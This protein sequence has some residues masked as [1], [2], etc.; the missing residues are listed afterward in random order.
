M[1]TFY[2]ICIIC[3][4][5]G[6]GALI[7]YASDK[8]TQK[9]KEKMKQLAQAIGFSLLGTGHN[10][11]LPEQF[12]KYLDR[13]SY[14]MKR[15]TPNMQVII[16]VIH[17]SKNDSSAY[18]TALYFQGQHLNLPVFRI[19]PKPG[20]LERPLFDLIRQSHHSP[21]NIEMTAFPIFQSCYALQ[22]DDEQAI[23]QILTKPVMA[24]YESD[25]DLITESGGN[26]LFIASGIKE[27]SF[28]DRQ[29][30]FIQNGFEVFN[31]LAGNILFIPPGHRGEIHH[32]IA[33]AFQ[34]QHDT[35]PVD[36]LLQ[37]LA[38]PDRDTCWNAIIT[39]G[40]RAERQAVEPLLRLFADQKSAEFQEA[41]IWAL[42]KIGD[43]RAIQPLM[44]V[45]TSASDVLRHRAVEALTSIGAACA[46]SAALS[47]ALEYGNARTQE[48]TTQALIKLGS[49][50]VPSVIPFLKHKDAALRSQG[51]SILSQIS[52][53]P[54]NELENTY[55]ILAGQDWEPFLTL[56]AQA[57]PALTQVWEESAIEE[58][59][60]MLEQLY[61][62]IETVAFGTNRDDTLDPKSTLW[63]P[64]VSTLTLAM[65]GLERIVVDA[66]TY[67]F[68]QVERF[69][70]YAVNYIGQDYLKKNVEVH[71]YGDPDKL[72][73]NLQNNFL[74][75]CK[76]VQRQA[77]GNSTTLHS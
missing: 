47:A 28:L 29:Q 57:I 34:D 25:K 55:Y 60:T 30:A 70:T 3:I 22:G 17:T 67:D 65:P 53:K 59:A 10:Y 14:A 73:P 75:L 20:L 6:L 48:H 26:W 44:P 50:A 15:Q 41:A 2:I 12:Q 33:A 52:W 37:A 19:D 74:N 35:R 62:L 63:N 69:L 77:P 38:S 9:E 23:R 56:G 32:E 16:F 45:L 36:E 21:P 61:A 49:A 42:G 71:V 5:I 13:T 68:H 72:H 39:L 8:A 1:E 58:V 46:D 64:E 54:A 11:L 40:Q 43:A 51:A 24:F 27:Q 7:L 76:Q 18:R 66:D 31:H 4:L